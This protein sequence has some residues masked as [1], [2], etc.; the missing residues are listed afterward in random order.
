[1]AAPSFYDD[2]YNRFRLTIQD[3]YAAYSVDPGDALGSIESWM[4]E[5]VAM[6]TRIAMGVPAIAYL[7]PDG[8]TQKFDLATDLKSLAQVEG[9]FISYTN[10]LKLRLVTILDY[11]PIPR[12]PHGMRY[13]RR[14]GSSPE[15]FVAHK[16]T[17]YAMDGATTINFNSV[18]A[19]PVDAD[20]PTEWEL[21]KVDYWAEAAT[22]VK[23][24]NEE[25]EYP[26]SKKSFRSTV[27]SVMKYIAGPEIRG[28]I[29]EDIRKQ[30]ERGM[31]DP[32]TG[33]GVFKSFVES[34]GHHDHADAP[35][36]SELGDESNTAYGT[37]LFGD[38]YNWGDIGSGSG[39]FPRP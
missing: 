1:M 14:I 39:N 37:D 36:A 8:A 31:R 2:I 12:H 38:A 4:N 30:G 3:T 19:A 34:L 15:G 10:F 25:P 21:I 24:S 5:A 23:D 22:L 33:I 20:N 18:M 6:L 11:G 27:L 35:I 28:D 13:I 7:H 29:G 17:G 32:F 26:V 16:P 9:E